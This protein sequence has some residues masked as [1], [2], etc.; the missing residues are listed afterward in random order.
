MPGEGVRTPLRPLSSQPAQS[1]YGVKF[2]ARRMRRMVNA[3]RDELRQVRQRAKS[4]S[5]PG[6]R[7][8]RA[9]VWRE[10][11]WGIYRFGGCSMASWH[12]ETGVSD[13][14]H[15]GEIG[16]FGAEVGGLVSVVSKACRQ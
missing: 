11:G 9:D 12:G 2:F 16:P 5:M 7:E 15:Y 14:G 1:L 10:G 4:C 8:S 6:C 13:N 3:S